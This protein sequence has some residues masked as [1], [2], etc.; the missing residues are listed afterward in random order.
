MKD[1][2]NIEL[3]ERY[4]LIYSLDKLIIIEIESERIEVINLDYKNALIT[5]D[6]KVLFNESSIFYFYEI[7]P[8]INYKQIEL[9]SIMNMSYN[10]END[11]LILIME[12]FLG[13][14]N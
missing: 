4:I 7:F 10:A 12:T 11:L 3:Y 2:F 14:N 9:K 5:N 8:Q 13:E 1:Y 6:G